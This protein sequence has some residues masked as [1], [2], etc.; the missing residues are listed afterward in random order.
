MKISKKLILCLI[1]LLLILFIFGLGLVLVYSAAEGS[2]ERLLVEINIVHDGYAETQIYEAFFAV[3][4][5]ELLRF[6]ERN[7][8]KIYGRHRVFVLE[9]YRIFDPADKMIFIYLDLNE[10]LKEP[11]LV[12]RERVNKLTDVKSIKVFADKAIEN[13]VR[14][15]GKKRP[16]KHEI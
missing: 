3:F 7:R 16:K 1:I 11:L 14:I 10:S 9:F 13:L 12:H 8:G 4:S 15:I 2:E 6:M 5:E